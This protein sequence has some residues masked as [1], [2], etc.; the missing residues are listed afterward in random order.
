LFSNY[1]HIGEH[2]SDT[3]DTATDAPIVELLARY[4]C[5]SG[6]DC[7]SSRIFDIPASSAP[8][9]MV[10]SHRGIPALCYAQTKQESVT[11]F[12]VNSCF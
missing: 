4:L 9:E 11:N 5:D 2:L 3:V 12:W 6:D 8:V 1:M 10:F 7:D